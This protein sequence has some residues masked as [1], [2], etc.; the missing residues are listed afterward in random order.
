MTPQSKLHK[1]EFNFMDARQ[2]IEK[3]NNLNQNA[4]KKLLRNSAKGMYGSASPMRLKNFYNTKNTN[5][6]VFNNRNNSGNI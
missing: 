6:K 4:I 2:T 1:L 3:H 5:L